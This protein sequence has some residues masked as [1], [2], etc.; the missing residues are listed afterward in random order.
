[1]KTLDV[2]KGNVL[3]LTI[4]TTLWRL[5]VDIVWPFLA[6]YVIAL[7]GNY[8]TIGQVMAIGN[9]AAIILYPLGGYIADY[10]GRIKVMSY[11]TFVYGFS[12]LIY[13]FTDSWEWVAIGMFIQSLVT[14]Y[15]PAMQALMA[16]SLPPG[17]R[18]VGFAATMAIPSAFGIASPLIGGWLIGVYGIKPAVKGLYFLGFLVSLLVGWIRLK[19]L[20][21]TLPHGSGIKLTPEGI[22][23]LLFESYRNII[24]VIREAPRRLISL[25]LIMSAC[26]LVTSFTSSFWIVRAKEVIGMTTQQ[27]GVLMLVNGVINVIVSIPAGRYVDSHNKK[28]IAGF[29]LMLGSIPVFFFLKVAS[30]EQMLLIGVLATFP[31][32]FLNPAFQA[33]FA[34]L[35][36]RERRGRT[37][38]ALGGGGITFMGNAWG[39]GIIAMLCAMTGN[40]LSG[41]LYRLDNS[42]PWLILSGSLIVLGILFLM[43]V[44]EAD[45][46]EE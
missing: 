26:V 17:S 45:K 19:K 10:Q 35:V 40:L 5:S 20:K 38:A 11:M 6:L 36:P 8:E 2:L 32:A 3:V 27:W 39:N 34:D 9:V 43:I 37:I 18:G 42:L 33:I 1:M 25:T 24:K 14:F 44:K 31:S 28:K 7:G 29:C 46:P 21:E 15:T 13:V 41:Y 12:F 23:R 30:F 16:D 4:C 22:P